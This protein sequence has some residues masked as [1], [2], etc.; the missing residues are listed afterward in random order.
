MRLDPGDDRY[1]SWTLIDPRGDQEPLALVQLSLIVAIA[2]SKGYGEIGLRLAA[3]ADMRLRVV[4][5][6]GDEVERQGT[7][8]DRGQRLEEDK[9]FAEGISRQQH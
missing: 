7:G 2:V 3:V 8:I 1:Q 5:T 6:F 9:L 4:D